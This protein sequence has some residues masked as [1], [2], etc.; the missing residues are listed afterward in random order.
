MIRRPPRS[1]LFPYTTLFRS[2]ARGVPPVRL[3]ARSGDAEAAGPRGAG[4]GGAEA[5]AVR[6]H[7]RRTEIGSA[8]VCTPVTVTY[9][10]PT[11]AWQNISNSTIS[12][13]QDHIPHE[14]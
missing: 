1:T 3:G 7:A 11:S 9:R 12:T 4:R 13:T 2:G 8:H 14:R 5:A 6:A 10:M